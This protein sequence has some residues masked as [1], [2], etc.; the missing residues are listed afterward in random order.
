[1]RPSAP[2]EVARAT[3]PGSAVPDLSLYFDFTVQITGPA[4]RADVRIRGRATCV[5]EFGETW[6][7]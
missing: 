3:F 2:R 1:M 4:F 7:Y 5:G 6:I